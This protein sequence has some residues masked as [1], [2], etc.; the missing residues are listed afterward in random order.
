M[1]TILIADEQEI[2]RLG[3]RTIIESLPQKYNVI[4]ATT[5]NNIMQLL[6]TRG[7]KYTILDMFL[8][9]GNIFSTVYGLTEHCQTTGILVYSMKSE[10]IYATRLIQKGIRGFVSK[11]T[12]VEELTNAISCLLK[13]EIYLSPAMKENLVRP[14]KGNNLQN[15][16]DTLSDRELEVIEYVMTGMGPKEI[17]RKIQLDT[18]TVSTYRRRAFEKLD[19]QNLIELKEKFLLYKTQG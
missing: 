16:I 18:T 17:A 3:L 9:D 15:P 12:T 11:R 7:I 2:I 4:E 13:G 1:E 6:A 14:G 5:C 19:V 10:K 8:A